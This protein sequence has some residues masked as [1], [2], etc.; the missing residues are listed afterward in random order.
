MYKRQKFNTVILVTIV[1]T[2]A[3]FVKAINPPNK[4][5]FPIGFWN[6]IRQSS[7]IIQYGDPGWL[8]HISLRK[9]EMSQRMNSKTINFVI[10]DNFSLPILLGQ[11]SDASGQFS[12]N[13]FQNLLFDSNPN[14]SMTNY[15]NQISYGQFNLTGTVYGW[16]TADQNMNY[17][18]GTSNG[19]AGDF[20]NN[21]GGYVLNIVQKSDATVDYSLYDNDGLD[22]IPNS[23]DDDGYADAVGVI[24]PGAGAD[25]SPSNNNIWPH[26]SSLGNNEYTTN[27]ISANGGN[28][29]VNTYFVCPEEAGGGEGNNQIRQIGVYVHEFGHVL[30]LPDLYDITDS[31]EEPDFDDSEGLG[32]WCLMA[33]GA[34]GGDSGHDETPTH[35]S[36]WCKMEMGWIQPTVIT[37]NQS[38]SIKNQESN[39]D[40]YLIW[41]DQHKLSR[42]FLI[43][44]RQ[45]TGFDKDLRG[46][47]LLIYHVDENRY[48]GSF[49]S[50]FGPGN[51]DETH[52]LVDLEEADG[53]AD[54]DNNINRS[55]AG[56]PYP[57]S[58]GN[59][60]FWDASSPNSKDYDGL[61]TGIEIKNI[62][63]SGNTM[64]A[65]VTIRNDYGYSIKYD[66]RGI[67]HGLGYADP[68]DMWGGVHFQASNG[69]FLNSVDIG[70]GWYLPYD[71]EIMVY[72]SFDGNAPGNLLGKI[73]SSAQMVAGTSDKSGW[74]TIKFDYVIAISENQQFFVVLKII[75]NIY[76]ITVD[77][78]GVSSGR[79]Y[80]SL[81]GITYSSLGSDM[82]LRARIGSDT[83]VGINDE[84]TIPI[85]FNL[86]QNFP[87][88]FNP[89]T[90]INY[91]ITEES[92]VNI[93]IYDLTGKEVK[94]LINEYQPK[95]QHYVI[96]N[97]KNNAGQ[98]VSGGV[99]FYKLQASDLTQ[100][101]KMVLLK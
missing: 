20:S 34:W 50:L 26:Q 19:L 15:Y 59:R 97:G 90:S 46:D 64:T 67:T 86:N 72:D 10:Q 71:Y 57:G 80:W 45:K 35:M 9:T 25:W 38:I 47:G 49:R 76:S 96:W 16:F 95:G 98:A 13:D 8:K 7:T 68:V 2:M 36:A 18:A 61:P 4:G 91:E 11:Y 75:N 70:F 101:R 29:K 60:T 5:T 78:V 63:D 6:K 74:F 33:G 41:E 43:E 37:N 82:N 27:D 85:E 21:G 94:T 53:N 100:T 40:A 3:T 93:I 22:G 79:S 23:G 52:K 17:Y 12:V 89:F 69:G 31:S 84:S 66:E 88:P 30:G 24:Y 44:N 48:W 14:G 87:N 73:S 1:F 83:Q 51:T 58:S 28:I 39:S 62:S 32:N 81:D 55:D 99:Y 54:L 92:N 56:D 77:W 65:D 42:Y